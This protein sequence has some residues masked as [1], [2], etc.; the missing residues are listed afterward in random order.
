[1]LRVYALNRPTKDGKT[2]LERQK[3]ALESCGLDADAV[4]WEKV[5]LLESDLTVA[6]FGLPEGTLVEVRFAGVPRYV[7]LS[8]QI[9]R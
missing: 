5:V 4:D 3:L 8:E 1:M 2:L 6:N 9:H 7:Q